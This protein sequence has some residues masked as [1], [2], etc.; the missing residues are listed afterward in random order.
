MFGKGWTHVFHFRESRG[1][2]KRTL[3]PQGAQPSPQGSCRVHV[4]ISW[5]MCQFIYLC[6][7][8]VCLGSLSLH[9][10]KENSCVL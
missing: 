6:L 4:S 3:L 9:I 2:W 10:I 7:L 5:T 1:L 8:S